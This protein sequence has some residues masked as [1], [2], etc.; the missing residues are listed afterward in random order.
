MQEGK[1]FKGRELEQLKEFLKKMN[2]DYDEGLEYNVCLYNENS[3]IIG[4]G[5]AEQNVLKCIA[6][7]PDYQGQGL[8]GTIISQLVQYEYEQGRT[9]ILLYTK[10]VNESMFADLGFYTIIKTDTV[11]FMENKVHGFSSWLEKL[12]N[13]TPAQAMDPG[14]T[15]GCIVA[16]CNPFTVGHRY[17]IEEALKQC[18]YLH[19]F[20]LS[21]K[22]S[23][24]SPDI[25]YQM[26]QTGTSDLPRVILHKTSDY[27]VS[28]ATFPTYFM[29]EKAEA[30]KANCK[31]DLDLYGRFIAP[32]LHIMKR[33]VGTEPDCRVT[34]FYN[35]SMKRQLP[36]YGINVLEIDRKEIGSHIVS[37][38]KIREKI[39]AGRYDL[40]KD[41][42]PE[43]VQKYIHMRGDVTMYETE[44][45]NNMGSLFGSCVS[46]SK[47]N[48]EEDGENKGKEQEL[49]EMIDDYIEQA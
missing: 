42:I 35:Q 17:L 7:H 39:K 16:N 6:I 49:F 40:V 33:F 5:S 21:D 22:R 26:V 20:V 11:L 41:M 24:Y 4:T 3:E 28:A 9:H 29:K 10:P 25:R 46:C 31:L 36:E 27:I 18:D 14:K 48:V 32:G 34:C 37:A 43:P 38:S 44:K 30:E 15:I 12:I 1:P 23:F 8:A 13:E 2:L 19:V 47:F 45:K